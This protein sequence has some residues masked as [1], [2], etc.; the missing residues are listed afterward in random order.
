MEKQS[1]NMKKAK[2]RQMASTKA[3]SPQDILSFWFEEIKPEQWFAQSK[4]FDALIAQRFGD[5]HAQAV[6]GELDHWS[7]TPEGALALI[8]ILDQFSRNLFR[9]SSKAFASDAKAISNA[10]IAIM[11]GFD[12]KLANKAMRQFMYM[13]FMHSEDLVTQD[14]GLK[15]FASLNDLE[16]LGYAQHH[17]DIIAQ[18]GR[19]PYRNEILKR[20]S[21]PEEVAFSKR[22]H[23]G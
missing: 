3:V 8:I 19:F 15:L 1:A 12:K 14:E 18:F 13:P 16:T 22:T 2:R 4:D 11:A 10:R 7:T 17:R 23:S 21:T 5:A 6:R 20:T 9:S